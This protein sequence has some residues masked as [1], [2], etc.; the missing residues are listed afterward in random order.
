MILILQTCVTTRQPSAMS[1]CLQF[2]THQVFSTTVLHNVC[3]VSHTSA[4]LPSGKLLCPLLSVLTERLLPS[5]LT[6]KSTLARGVLCPLRHTQWLLMNEQL[7][8]AES[9]FEGGQG[10]LVGVTRL[11]LGNIAFPMFS[12][13][14][15][16]EKQESYTV[17]V[18]QTLPNSLVYGADWS[19]LYFRRLPQTQ[20]SFCLGSFPCSDPEAGTT[21]VCNQKVVG[22]SPA[23]SSDHLA[24]DD[25]EGR[26]RLQRGGKPRSSFQLLTENSKSSGQLHTVGSKISDD[27]PRL[28][29]ANSDS[30]LLATCSFYDHVLHLW[31][32]Q[33]S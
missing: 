25:G 30:T 19:W 16:E 29:G 6:W 21:E 12:C 15:P 9:P 22:Q 17:S 4:S 28:E 26:T 23:P 32:W 3:S 1:T 33:N 7:F 31:K 10:P 27:D 5:P 18:S 11:T 2:L 20:Q 24:D 14:T 13:L 8:L